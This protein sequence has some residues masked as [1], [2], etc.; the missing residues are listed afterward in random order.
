MSLGECM[1]GSGD[2][3]TTSRSPWM[4]VET[5]MIDT[6][7]GVRQAYDRRF[8]ALGLNLSQALLVSLVV[9]F[10]P[11]TQTQLAEVL[12]LGRAATGSCVD[13]L[14]KRRLVR[15]DPDPE[16]RR[17]WIVTATPG[18]SEMAEEIRTID[19]V[20]QAE[21]R[22]GITRAERQQLA[23]LLIKMQANLEPILNEPLSPK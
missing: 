11:H 17:V 4:R 21:L 6:S 22:N 2:M 13:Q 16:D 9:D 20:L 1:A 14:E 8:A 10:G 12:N 3:K 7:R 19:Q 23:N 5:A 15:R 18:G